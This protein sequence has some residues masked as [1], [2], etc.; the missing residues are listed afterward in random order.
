MNR[1]LFTALTFLV[2][3]VAGVVATVELRPPTR[4]VPI[5]QFVETLSSEG[6][7]ARD[8]ELRGLIAP[9][10]YDVADRLSAVECPVAPIT[11]ARLAAYIDSL[12]QRSY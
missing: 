4:R 6:D 1:L 5:A 9:V 10:L 3:A 7:D 8:A 11:N 12:K 2:G